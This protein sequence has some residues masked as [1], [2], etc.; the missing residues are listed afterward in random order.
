[1][2]EEGERGRVVGLVTSGVLTGILVSRSISGL[3]A[4]ATGWRVIYAAAAVLAVLLAGVLA[5]RIPEL[6]AREHIRYSTLLRSIGQAIA[7]QRI[8]RWSLVLGATQFGLFTL[9]WTALT[10]Y[11]STAPYHYSV[12]KIGL[13]GLFGLTGAL[14]AQRAGRLHDRG[15]SLPATGAGW[16]L[17]V[18]SFVLVSFARHSVVMLWSTGGSTAITWTGTVVATIGFVVWLL[19]RRGPLVISIG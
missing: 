8:V 10:F 14:A 5:V 2:A 18:A 13:F 7:R 16:A 6:P 11:L 3:V 9:F 12:T 4:G 19:G 1:M 17:V 15:W